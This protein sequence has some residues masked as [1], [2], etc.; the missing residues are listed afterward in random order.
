M[1]IIDMDC[2]HYENESLREIIDYIEDPVMK[3]GALMA[4]AGGTG[5]QTS[6]LPG[7]V[8]YQDIAGRIHA[9]SLAEDRKRSQPVRSIAT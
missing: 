2:H 5:V 4:T 8:G 9:L 6:F 7:M 1:L 3:Q